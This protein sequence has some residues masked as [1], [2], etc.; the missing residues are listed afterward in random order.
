MSNRLILILLVLI[1]LVAPVISKAQLI[2]NFSAT[3]VTGCT[4]LSVQFTDSSTGNP[5]SWNWDLGNGTLSN[6]QNPTTAYLNSGFYTVSLTV[7]NGFTSNTKIVTNYINVNPS[8][9]VFFTVNDSTL[10]CPPKTVQF[11]NQSIL[12]AVGPAT[13]FWDFGDGSTSTLQNPTHTYIN[14]GNFTVTLSV[15]NA[16]GCVK[17]KT[18]NNYIPVSVPPNVNFTSNNN[19]SCTVPSTVNFTNTTT[20]G[21]SYVWSFGTTPNTTATTFNA[22]HTYTNAGSYTIKLTATNA[23]GCVDSN[24]KPAFV[25]IGPISVNFTKSASSVCKGVSVNFT[26]TTTPSIGSCT[27][28]FGDGATANSINANHA[29]ANPGT[30]TVKLIVITNGCKDSNMQTVVVQPSPTANFT[31]NPTIGC[32]VPQT[33]AFT[34]S[35]TG[36][37]SYLWSFGTGAT[38]NLVNPSYTYNAMGT[39]DV[40][41]IAI[42]SNNC[43]DTLTQ[44]GYINFIVPTVTISADNLNGCAPDSVT[45]TATSTPPLTNFNWNLGNGTIIPGGST[46]TY[47]YNNTGI[48]NVTVSYSFAPGCSY[49]TLPIVVNVGAPPIPLFNASTIIACPNQIVNFTNNSIAPIGTTYLWDF[50]DASTDTLIN[51]SHIFWNQGVYNVIL[52][53]TN[54]GCSAVDSMSITITPPKSSFSIVSGLCANKKTI[55]TIDSSTLGCIYLWDFGDG[56]TSNLYNTTHTYT[57]FGNYIVKLK[58]TDTITGCIAEN[59]LNLNLYDLTGNF[60]ASDTAMCNNK[61]NTFLAII[62]TSLIGAIQSYTWYFGDG[63]SVVDTDLVTTHFYQ[64]NGIFNVKLVLTDT[65]GC[66]DTIIKQ[67]YIHVGGPIVN[68]VGSPTIGCKPLTVLFTDQTVSPDGFASRNWKFGNGANSNSNTVNVTNVYNQNGIFDVR[69]IVTDNKGCKDTLIKNNYINVSKPN[70]SFTANDTVICKG[71]SVQF[72]SSNTGSLFWSFGDGGTSTLSN[73]SHVYTSSGIFTVSLIVT[74]ASGCK[75]T[76]IRTNYINVSKI[77]PGFTM[78]DSFASCPPLTVFFVDTTSGATSRHWTLGNGNTSTI[79]NPGSIY[80]LPGNYSV[81]LVTSNGVCTDSITHNIVVLGPIGSFSYSPLSGCYPLTVSFVANTQSTTK[82]TWYMSNGFSDSSTTNQSPYTFNYNYTYT[83]TGNFVPV[84]ILSNGQNCVIPYVGQDTIKVGNLEADFNFNVGIHCENASVQFFDTVFNTT[85]LISSRFW[86]FGDGG[87]STI[88]NPTHVY[89]IAGTYNVKLIISAANGCSDTI[90]KQITILP[91]PTLTVSNGITACQGQFASIS[92]TA[93]GAATYLWS[94]AATVGCSTCP[95]TFAFPSVPTTYTVIG[96]SLN[97]CKDTGFVTINIDTVPQVN[98]TNSQTICSNTPIQ[99]AASGAN[100]FQWSPS[101]GLSCTN[102][103]NPIANP[104]TNTTFT[105]IGTNI[106][107]CSDTQQ[108]NLTVVAAPNVSAGPDVKICIYGQVQLSAS[109]FSLLNWVSEPTLS[110]S[111]CPNPIA[112]PTVTTP[113][114]VYTVDNSGCNDTDTV[115]VFVNTQPIVTIGNDTTICRG[116]SVQLQVNG[117]LYYDWTPPSN[118]TCINCVNPIVYPTDTTVYFVVGVDS[119]GCKDT[120]KITINVFPANPIS[121]GTD[122]SICVGDTVH[123][124]ATGGNQYLWLPAA[125]LSSDTS[126]NPL[127]FPTETTTYAVIIKQGLCNSD[128]V[129]LKITVYPYPT[130]NAGPDKTIISG[131]N[132]NL[133]AV[134]TNTVK[135]EWTPIATLSCYDCQGP[136]ASPKENTTYTVTV[137]NEIGC[138]AKDDVTIYLICDNSQL[139]FAN[140]FTPNADGQNDRFFP[141]GKGLMNIMQFSIFNRWGEKIFEAK[142]FEPNNEF[143]GWDGTYKGDALNPDVFVYVAKAVCYTGEIIEVKGDVSLLR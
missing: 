71:E 80:T 52:T 124:M 61:L 65:L 132:V 23:N 56:T 50:G 129:F 19:L 84:F 12:G 109:G 134:S 14:G 63:T 68:F 33:V 36:A 120:S 29:Y 141:Q 1:C 138:E 2:A 35:S 96:T 37:S 113:Y 48:Y 67:N 95:S 45:F 69:L 106:S 77:I 142:D 34:N 60:I 101:T 133:L 44:I 98:V 66:K 24:I 93:S 73:P 15:T 90:Q 20:G 32:N 8:P 4:P 125:T 22:S 25:N 123:L 5:T 16:S 76:M 46:L 72:S 88:H 9:Q 11:T 58:V 7:S 62:D 27:W 122:D 99:M 43:K 39:Y 94:P 74:N 82:I 103:A 140:T 51:P 21:V 86:I 116:D 38:S 40:S 89:G 59:H 117:A 91:A 28:Q 136:I 42:S 31:A 57:N 108:V 110:C 102:C 79:I 104:Q 6:L 3:P 100:N 121:Y 55:T 17:F 53:A 10:T 137:Y 64:T 135:Y 119:N 92:I 54:Q 126:A 26:N 85:S 114:I 107:G 115:V 143:K 118:I 111:N 75:D 139:F 105:V 97:G 112:S 131:D 30:Y 130:V 13:Y 128:T 70:A 49:T 78:S 127:A 83:Q 18:K 87:T 81:K 47:V 41:L